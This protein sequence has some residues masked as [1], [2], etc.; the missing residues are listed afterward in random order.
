VKLA[1]HGIDVELPAGWEG[2]IYRSP[3][4]EPILHAASFA[5]PGTDGDFGSGAT[6]Q[7]SEGGAFV[8]LKEYR[9]GPRL[10]PGRGLF[11]SGAIPLPLDLERFHPRALQVGRR[12][13]A[14]YQHFFTTAGR[15][16]C[17]YV[18]ISTAHIAVAAAAAHQQLGDLSRV[19]AS[20]S[21]AGRP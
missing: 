16:F 17:L 8:A 14:G 11:A 9:P 10:H 12:G 13:Q 3:G 21:I 15:P 7:M 19:V 20:V 4:S 6:G 5:L 2:R 18:V 1:A